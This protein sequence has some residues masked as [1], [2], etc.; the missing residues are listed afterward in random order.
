MPL[1][2]PTSPPLLSFLLI[3]LHCL[4]SP[5]CNPGD[6]DAATSAEYQHTLNAISLRFSRELVRGEEYGREMELKA[7][8]DVDSVGRGND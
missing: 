5:L 4:S 8:L 1:F 6:P 3:F 7:D 2:Y